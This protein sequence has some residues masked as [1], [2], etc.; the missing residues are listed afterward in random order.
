MNPSGWDANMA[1]WVVS[2]L[3]AVG[4][5]TWVF[6]KISRRSNM[7]TTSYMAAGFVG[8]IIF[9]FFITFLKVI[10]HR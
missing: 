2:A 4:I 3:F 5:G 7:L 1:D 8:A 10:L 6:V 9:I